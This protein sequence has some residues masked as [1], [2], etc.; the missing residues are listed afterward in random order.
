MNEREDWTDRD[1]LAIMK[2]WRSAHRRGSRWATQ[3]D[4][5]R[6]TVGLC[7]TIIG[8]WLRDQKPDDDDVDDICSELSLGKPGNPL[9]F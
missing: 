4:R 6:Q 5:A 8:D 9:G 3:Q 7:H 2:A 1:L